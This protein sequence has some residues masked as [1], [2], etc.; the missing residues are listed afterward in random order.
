MPENRPFGEAQDIMTPVSTDGMAM[1]AM[2]EALRAATRAVDRQS[3]KVDSLAS[4]VAKIREDIAVMHAR[5]EQMTAMTNA[6]SQLTADVLTIKL[7]HAQQEGGFKLANLAKDW[8]P[9]L[10]TFLAA[11]WAFFGKHP[12]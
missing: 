4:S 8:A 2:I 11:V 7:L 10:L 1:A 9:W 6:I 5:E 3:T 12:S